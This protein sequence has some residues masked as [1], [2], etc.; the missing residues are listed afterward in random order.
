MSLVMALFR[1]TVATN[2]R[3]RD[4]FLGDGLLQP[5]GRETRQTIEVESEEVS[6]E[7]KTV[8]VRAGL[9]IGVY[10]KNP[11]SNP[12]QTDVAVPTHV[13]QYGERIRFPAKLYA[14]RNFHNPGSFDYRGFLA[15][16]GSTA[17]GST[18]AQEIELL[19]GFGGT[20]AGSWRARIHRSLTRKIQAIWP[21]EQAA[22]RGC[23]A[24]GRRVFHGPFLET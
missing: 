10:S 4:M 12:D 6:S 13:F 21:E 8:R 19:Q 15:D 20:W 3:L 23:H 9:R 24:F 5:E 22:H 14:P 2:Y 1:W 18:K 16:K 7:D 11:P 17:L